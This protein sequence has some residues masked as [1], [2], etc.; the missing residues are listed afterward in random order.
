MSISVKT[1]IN[2]KKLTDNIQPKKKQELA[3]LLDRVLIPVKE[4]VEEPAAK[5]KV[6][7]TTGG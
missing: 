2:K 3:K 7:L 5:I 1:A 4:S 6:L